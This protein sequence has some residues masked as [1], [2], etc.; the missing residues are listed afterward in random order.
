MT[1]VCGVHA[2]FGS[3][4]SGW[5][6]K[7]SRRASIGSHLLFGREHAALEFDCGET[8]FVDDALGLRDDGVRVEGLAVRV[9]LTARV[10]AHL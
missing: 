7:A 5:S 1:D 9:R 8:V 6:G 10:A 3:S 2:A 4:R